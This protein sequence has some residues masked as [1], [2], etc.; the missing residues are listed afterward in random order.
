MAAELS[1]I[2]HHVKISCY[3]LYLHCKLMIGKVVDM[4]WTPLGLN[5]RETQNKKLFQ[6]V[7]N[8][9]YLF[10]CYELHWV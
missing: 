2:L 8:T 9:L 5:T 6:P 3:K 4:L 10:T 1:E 7:A